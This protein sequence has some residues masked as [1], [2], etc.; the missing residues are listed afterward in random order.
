MTPCS[1]SASPVPRHH[2]EGA[3]KRDDENE[4]GGSERDDD[5]DDGTSE[6]DTTAVPTATE[7]K[8]DLEVGTGENGGGGFRV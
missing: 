7:P 5:D 3:T 1:Q 8:L 4:E 2:D 6:R